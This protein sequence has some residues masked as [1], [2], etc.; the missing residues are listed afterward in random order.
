MEKKNKQTEQ[1]QRLYALAY[2]SRTLIIFHKTIFFDK[3][4]T[5]NF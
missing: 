3:H 2:I 5:I 1:K 4:I